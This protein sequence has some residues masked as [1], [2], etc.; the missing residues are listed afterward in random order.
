[1]TCLQ[2]VGWLFLGFSQNKKGVRFVIVAN[3]VQETSSVRR[4][5]SCGCRDQRRVVAPGCWFVIGWLLVAP[6]ERPFCAELF[7]CDRCALGKNTR[8]SMSS[9]RAPSCR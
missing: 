2:L 7:V 1:V 6:A 5:T 9:V 8:K 4:A 3:K